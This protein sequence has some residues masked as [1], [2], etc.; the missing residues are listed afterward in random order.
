MWSV[1]LGPSRIVLLHDVSPFL[2]CVWIKKWRVAGQVPP[3][4]KPVWG[5]L[6]YSLPRVLMTQAGH[7]L[8][9]ALPRLP[10]DGLPVC[11][12]QLPP[13]W[14]LGGNAGPRPPELLPLLE[15]GFAMVLPP[16]TVSFCG[17]RQGA[18]KLGSCKL[19]QGPLPTFFQICCVFGRGC[20]SDG[21]GVIIV[22]LPPRCIIEGDSVE[23]TVVAECAFD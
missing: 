7:F 12:G 15:L 13:S 18:A 6:H 10:P 2:W 14:L 1:A 21:L 17:H 4:S 5:R 19:Y 11:E 16:C 20:Y 22:N 3:L 9:A 8:G 23:G